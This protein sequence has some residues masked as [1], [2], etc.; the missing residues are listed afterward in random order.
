LEKVDRR[1]QRWLVAAAVLASV[2]LFVAVVALQ[3]LFSVG[4][5]SGGFA[6][7]RYLAFLFF[8]IISPLPQADF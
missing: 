1:G 5:A 7:Q 2:G 3:R 8:Q 6:S 4:F